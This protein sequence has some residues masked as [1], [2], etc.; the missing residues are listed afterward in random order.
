MRIFLLPALFLLSATAFGDNRGNGGDL[1]KNGG[2][3]QV[4]EFRNLGLAV[5]EQ[6]QNLNGTCKTLVP[7]SPLDLIRVIYRARIESSEEEL[8]I[9][10]RR[11][12][13]INYPT[14]GRIVFHRPSF[15]AN[16]NQKQF[17]THE[18]LGLLNVADTKGE[19]EYG[20]SK[21]LVSLLER[22][23]CRAPVSQRKWARKWIADDQVHFLFAF[24]QEILRYDLTRD[25]Q[26]G[27]L[28]VPSA[29]AARWNDQWYFGHALQV[30]DAGGKCLAGSQAPLPLH[31]FGFV[32]GRLVQSLLGV[33][34]G[35]NP[36]DR[37]YS[38]ENL[39]I[40]NPATGGAYSLRLEARRGNQNLT[41]GEEFNYSLVREF[42]E[43]APNVGMAIADQYS[44]DS[45]R[46]FSILKMEW[47]E[48][49]VGKNGTLTARAEDSAVTEVRAGGDLL[50]LSQRF[51]SANNQAVPQTLFPVKAGAYVVGDEGS[52]FE[53]DGL[54]KVAIVEGPVADVAEY[55]DYLIVLSAGRI[56]VYNEKW[57][58]QGEFTPAVS[59]QAI[60]VQ[61]D[62]LRLFSMITDQ[63]LFV[64]TKSV[65]DFF[66]KKRSCLMGREAL[67]RFSAREVY[68]VGDTEYALA[69][70]EGCVLKRAAS[71]P[72]VAWMGVQKDPAQ[73]HF[74]EA[75]TLYLVDQRSSVRA[76]A[77]E[78]RD[79]T[80]LANFGD[81]FVKAVFRPN[82][83][84]LN[85]H[86][87]GRVKEYLRKVLINYDGRILKDG[88]FWN[89]Y[90]NEISWN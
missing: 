22:A 15:L 63:K 32:G 43:L 9:G 76:L 78:S 33:R 66:Q 10:E 6:L 60:A 79:E 73:V 69:A 45:R 8:K 87:A 27:P 86:Q 71:G 56:L 48:R 24:P 75:G 13:A 16:K 51:Y 47:K 38:F 20:L 54:E 58:L 67:A 35:A 77:L 83:I 49:N 29:K 62:S 50:K 5:A 65:N 21:F 90:P 82:E 23:D 88:G 52:V 44:G 64:D 89:K 3:G 72:W 31:E 12:E 81:E 40:V 26:A 11:V 14:L 4:I 85:M 34:D 70:A 61:G 46:G 37:F 25:S 53:T 41:P 74:N 1:V 2:D 59:P 57:H 28:A 42:H 68:R 55:G 19:E 7:F 39:R 36:F 18:F 80:L 84:E 30:C 17:V